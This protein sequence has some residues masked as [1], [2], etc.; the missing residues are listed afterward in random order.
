MS[1]A[2]VQFMI[3][4]P[5][6]K[7]L[8][9]YSQKV[10][11][12][13]RRT[14]GAVDVDSSLV[15]GKPQYGVTV[16]RAKAA[17][18]GVSIADVA[19]TLRLLVAGDKASDYNEKGEQYEV[20]VRATAEFR[21][22]LEELKQVSLPSSKKDKDLVAL[23]DVVAF[24]EGTGPAQINRLNRNRQVTI[25]CNMTPGTSQQAVLDEIERSVQGLQMGPDYTTGLLGKS[26]EMARTFRS[27]VLVF[28]IAV[29]FV[30]LVLAAQFESWLHPITILLSLPLTLPFA[31][32][33]LVL[34]GQSLNIF[35]LLGILVLFAVVKKNSILQIDHANQLR[36]AG[37]PRNEAILEA[38]RDRLR[39][40]LMTTVAFVAGM[41][42]LL[43][44]NREG[45]FDE[46]GHQR[47]GHR[48]S[49][50]VRC[51]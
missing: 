5:D 23:G 2:D 18:L 44:S 14:P 13:L 21:N 40:I 26:K 41:I 19:N 35:S 17:D 51:S 1:Q 11:Q 12:D 22:R 34:F 48:R 4:G 49:D 20:H 32:I 50:A 8:D 7:L 25:S 6:M 42:P 37:L 24:P 39:P 43:I 15:V 3:G 31:L 36:A 33:S 45:A 10:M 46:Q 9:Q 38:N 16:D 28:V 47:R 27:F 29:V 30:Y